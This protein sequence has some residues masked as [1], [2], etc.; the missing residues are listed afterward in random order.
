MLADEIELTQR[1]VRTDAYQMSL[2]ELVGMYEKSEL[3]IRPE[4]Q[5]LSD[6]T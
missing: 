6:G 1:T 4:F 5:R 2:G 3:I